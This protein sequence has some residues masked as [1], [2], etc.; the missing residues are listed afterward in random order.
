MYMCVNEDDC[1]AYNLQMYMIS[2]TLNKDCFHIS[3][4]KW[5]SLILKEVNIVDMDSDIL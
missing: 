1:H 3:Y 5:G 2:Y 4:R